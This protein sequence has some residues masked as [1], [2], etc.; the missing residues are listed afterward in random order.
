MQHWPYFSLILPIVT[1]FELIWPQPKE[2]YYGEAGVTVT[3]GHLNVNI[4]DFEGCEALRVAKQTYEN[5]WFFPQILPNS[6]APGSLTE[7]KLIKPS[8]F[9]C[10]GGYSY[11]KTI[12]D[13]SYHLTVTSAFSTL[14]SN[15][16]WGFLRGL[17]T[18][19]QLISHQP[20]KSISE[21]PKFTLKTAEIIDEPAYN[22]R[23]LM[24]DTGRHFLPVDVILRQI[25]LMAQSKFNVFH[26]HIVDV[27]SFPYHSEQ[28]ANL[29]ALGAFGPNAVYSRSDVKKV[30][31]Y[32]N[33][34]GIRVVPEFDTP[35]R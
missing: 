14:Q 3:K 9:Q 2:S 31:K 35:G 25:D 22:V 11:P 32:A 23:G 18:F 16:I 5:S 24:L 17:E 1:C 34:K 30:I 26:W 8:D 4:D 20:P 21:P 13:E 10:P 29:S 33:L 15:T 12:K 28:F 7:I 6:T 19:S 27:E